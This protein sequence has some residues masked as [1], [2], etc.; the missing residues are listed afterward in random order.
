MYKFYYT[1]GYGLT[2]YIRKFATNLWQIVWNPNIRKWLMRINL[3]CLVLIIAFMQI[4]LAANAQKISLSKKNAPLTEIFK[5]LRKQTGYAFVINKDQIKI[6]HTVTIIVDGEDLIN[7]LDKCFEGQ[8]FTYSME[9]KMIIVVNRKTEQVKVNAPPLIIS[10]S[11]TIVNDDKKPI[12]G[13]SIFIKGSS[14]GTLTNNNGYFRLNGVPDHAVLRIS[15]IGY[16]PVDIGIRKSKGGYSAY[17]IQKEQA[18]NLS[19]EAGDEVNF[20]LRLT[21][22][23]GELKGISV[24]ADIDPP[25]Q[26]GTVVDL[27]HRNHLN[28][29]QVLEGSV[30]GLTLKSST[31]TNKEV[32]ISALVYFNELKGSN[33]IFTGIDRQRELYNKLVANDPTF[34]VRNGSFETWYESNYYGANNT[35]FVGLLNNTN[36]TVNNG[37]VP[38]LR[39][40]SSFTGNTLGMLVVIDGIEQSS[41]PSTYPMSNVAKIEVV[42][43]PAELVKWGPKATGGLIMIT[44]N[45][46]KAGKLQFN[47]SSNFSYSGKPNISNAKLQLASTADVLAYY[48]EVV[49]KG[50]IT[51]PVG[52]KP[53]QRLLYNLKE[54][55]LPYTD[56]KFTASWDSL[57]R[58]SNRD[59]L[60]LLYQNVFTQ[61]HSLNITG[62]SPIWGFSLGSVYN[63]TPTTSIG[64]KS[65]DLQLNMQ[66][67]LNLL[68]NKLNI[69]WQLNTSKANIQSGLADDGS[70]LDPYQMLLYPDNAYVY[71]YSGPISEDENRTMQQL[72]YENNGVNPLE[73]ALNTKNWSKTFGIN[74]RINSLWELSKSL[75]WSTA[76]VYNRTSTKIHNVQGSA[77]SGVRQLRNNY[78]SPDTVSGVNMLIPNGGILNTNR[79]NNMSWNLRSGLSYKHIFD[80]RNVLSGAISMAATHTQ[81]T[82]IPNSPIYGY[83]PNTPGGIPLSQFEDGTM[84]DYF[85]TPLYLSNLQSRSFNR[86]FYDRSFS[87]NGNL[88]YVYDNRYSMNMQFGSVYTPNI[89][90]YPS[91]LSTKNYEAKA[92]WQVSNE[93]FFRVPFISNLTISAIASQIKLGQSPGQITSNPVDQPLWNNTSLVVS[94]YTPSQLNGQRIT[95][96]GGGLQIGLW[97]DRFNLY[98]S[99]NNSSDGSHQVNGQVVYNI[100][101]EP[102][103][104]IPFISKLVVDASLQNFNSLQAQAIVMGTNIPNT[105]GGFVLASNRNFGTLP[106]ATINKEAHFSLG[107]FKDRL[108]FDTRY[109]HKIVSSTSDRGLL[110][111]DPSTGIAS[112]ISYSRMLNKGVE[113]YLKGELIRGGNFGYTITINGAYNINQALD[114]PDI[115]F[116]QYAGYL[117][118]PRTGYA[119]DA[120]WSYRWAGLDNMGNPQVY[121]DID[122][123]VHILPGTDANGSPVINKLDASSL[124]YSGRIRAPWSGGLV[125]EWT[126]KE[127]FARTM[128]VFNLG[129]I[130]R[131]YIPVISSALDKSILIGKRWQK[132]GDEDH[133]DIAAMA[134]PNATRDL[135]I[136][137][138][139]NSIVSASNIRLREVQIGYEVPAYLLKQ[140]FIQALTISAQVQNLALWTRNKLSLDPDAVGSNGRV[141]IRQPQQYILSINAS[142]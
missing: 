112:Q 67:R 22:A 136:Q 1:N 89:G 18:E 135:V 92:S 42:K 54:N 53:A 2:S 52:I 98:G 38:E 57:A 131:T 20:T 56:P 125:Q 30:P 111:P 94:G 26:I 34:Q 75:Q 113:I 74:S 10:I 90:F 122:T 48:K 60:R 126:Y 59:Q 102:W 46:T 87:I 6:A 64:S 137:N 13:A 141:G 66:N 35:P 91:Y 61:N 32:S 104:H 101:R 24:N 23:V 62:G 9:D 71:D 134:Q 139:S 3:T 117:S 65:T 108:I 39:G 68:K 124:I 85:G 8:P 51:I 96:I 12:E 28:L 100:D 29:G 84:V 106:P 63:N 15:C 41:F 25:K 19:L 114:I 33:E 128:L 4:S 127:F 16:I 118:T 14:V 7:V 119:N 72:G 31:T 36:T 123:K 133:T 55:N 5:E 70:S 27:K 97:K 130:M 103:F 58:L 43:D 82:A 40:S 11:G 121:K 86:A 105:N 17:A 37:L 79:S 132:P 21:N 78:G 95:N 99:Y 110:P 140:R 115:P 45:G 80:A 88:G 69:T 76:F 50:F 120:L 49:D 44:T 47:Y 73:D 77:T 138:S 81:D 116:S 142:F 107:M 129:H 83:G 109:Y 93:A